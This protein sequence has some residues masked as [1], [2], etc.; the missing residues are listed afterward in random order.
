MKQAKKKGSKLTKKKSKE[1]APDEQEQLRELHNA[2]YGGKM[3]KGPCEKAVLSGKHGDYLV[4]T[5]PGTDDYVLVVNDTGTISNYL[6]TTE[7]GKFTIGSVRE[8]FVWTMIRRRQCLTG[9]SI[10]P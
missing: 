5:N 10:R 8:W 2:W 9:L 1:K 6:I 3:A 4:R 7:T